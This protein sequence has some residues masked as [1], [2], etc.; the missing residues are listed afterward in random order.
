MLNGFD[1]LRRSQS[2]TELLATLRYLAEEPEVVSSEKEIGPPVSA[3]TGPCRRCWIYPRLS[4]KD[5]YCQ[6]CKKIRDRGRKLAL[7]SRDAALIWGFVNQLP[8]QL[9][10]DGIDKK[11]Y[12]FGTY[13]HDTNSFLLAIAHR[14]IKVWIQDIVIHHGPDLKGL[15]QIFPTAGSAKKIGMGDLLC[16]AIHHEANLPMDR[17]RVRFYSNPY[18]LISPRERDQKGLLTF[19]I[20]E[21]LGL[22][23]MAEVFRVL[24]RPQEQKE[25]YEV[26]SIE[27]TMEKQFY[28]GRLLKRLDKAALDMLTAWN[29][30]NWPQD[31]IKLLYELFDY[32]TL[33][34]TN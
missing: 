3:L 24:I 26:L 30:R 8:K 7:L 11:S 9:Q 21:F 15:I 10:N 27:K 14:K 4:E 28:W 17:M 18:Q 13:I 19:E 31:R 16:R 32:V 29:I 2:G 34:Q 12:I 6:S 5:N 20:S 33:P 1:W 25:I 22:L 23:E